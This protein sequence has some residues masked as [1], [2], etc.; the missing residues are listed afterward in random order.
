MK[1]TFLL[2]TVIILTMPALRIQAEEGVSKEDFE[3]LK[4]AIAELKGENKALKEKLEPIQSSVGKALD[5]KYGPGAAVQTKTGKLTI[6]GLLQIWYYS[7]QNDNKGLF[8]DNRVNDITDTNEANDN[9]SFRIRRAEVRFNFDINE[10]IS[11]V[12]MLDPARE[13]QSFPTFPTNQGQFKRAAVSAT[14]GS[15]ANVQSGAGA[16]PRFLQDAYILY[17]GFVP[18][19]EFQIGQYKP[20]FS[21]E[22]FRSSS[23]LDFAER[24]FLGQ[25]G[26]VRDLGAHV[27]GF[28]WDER[29][30][31]WL[32]VFDNA[33]NFLGSG[34]QQQ[35]RS[36]DNDEKDF[37]GRFLIRPVWKNYTWG[38]LELGGAFQVGRHGES[39]TKNPI[40]SPL[41]GLNRL[42]TWGQRYTAW[43][44]Y[45]PGGKVEGW[46]LRGEWAR[47]KDRNQPSSVI[48]LLGNDI[49]GNGTQDYAKPV[50]MDGWYFSTGYKIGDSIFAGCV[51]KWFKPF[52]FAF[53]YESV[54]N[55]QVADLNKPDHTDVFRTQ[56]YTGGINYY[57]KGHNAKIQLN[58]NRVIDP[59]GRDNGG[60]RNFHQDLRNDSILANF[61]LAF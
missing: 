54:Q 34:G 33:G 17:K 2:A 18:H 49:D 48:D 61:Q 51:P 55:V 57:I 60:N 6:T 45:A 14:G 50:A 30:Q 29:I 56:V 41:N 43:A 13:A 23:T 15:I 1:K 10:N 27:R 24:S 9:D 16:A 46:W 28:W 25:L 31:Y 21:D 39:G 19:H 7:I 8:Q 47:Y 35:N 3:Q 38:S 22:A 58:Y 59:D 5:A 32:G 53:R 37:L 42:T 11:G 44:N 40:D 4:K 26:D 12:I 20:P 52:E 36:D